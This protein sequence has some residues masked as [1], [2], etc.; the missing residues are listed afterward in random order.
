M[1]KLFPGSYSL[2]DDEFKALWTQGMLVFDT[3]MLLNFHRYSE[4]T[5]REFLELVSLPEVAPRIWIPYQVA[6]EYH[7]N[8]DE[9]RYEQVR[10][11]QTLK[12]SIEDWGKTLRA[13]DH[14][15]RTDS[16]L[17]LANELLLD[18]ENQYHHPDRGALVERIADLFDGKV[19]SEWDTE[20]L[21]K[22][23]KEGEDRYANK[24][25]PG[26]RDASSK[27]GDD[28]FGDLI[29]WLQIIE[30]AGHRKKPVIFVT[31]DNKEDWWLRI[32]GKTIGPLPALRNEIHR[33]AGV[34]FHMYSGDRFLDQARIS[35]K[36]PVREETVAE[37]KQVRIEQEKHLADIKK[38]EITKAFNNML[39]RL[40]QS[41][42]HERR[43]RKD[44]SP[45][46]PQDHLREELDDL[47][48]FNLPG[49]SSTNLTDMIRGVDNFLE[50]HEVERIPESNSEAPKPQEG[51]PQEGEPKS[52]KKKSRD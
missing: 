7:R 11:C 13:G 17:K 38:D 52:T 22:A 12:Q 30:E 29:V 4:E 18:A 5:R 21:K 27:K 9:V 3:N 43:L 35:F 49:T 51:K 31:D 36:Q 20:R 39:L 37:V 8:L 25:P 23:Y 2:P 45:P 41:T 42:T 34:L 16:L 28:R 33:K 44:L 14:R 40:F 10:A 15:R 46:K 47:V 24:V 6:L 19:G 26:F 48:L 32:G 1:K 50:F